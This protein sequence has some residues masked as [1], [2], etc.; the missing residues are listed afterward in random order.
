MCYFVCDSER[1]QRLKEDVSRKYGLVLKLLD[2]ELIRQE[3]K[4][5][6]YKELVVKERFQDS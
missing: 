4:K 1:D 6:F 2:D 3:I 5:T